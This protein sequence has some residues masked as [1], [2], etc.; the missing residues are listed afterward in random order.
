MTRFTRWVGPIAALGVI[1]WSSAVARATV[2]VEVPLEDMILGAD[3][4]VHG[5]VIANDVRMSLDR[6]ELEPNTFVT[7]EVTEWLA[8]EGGRTVTLRELGGTFQGI[9]TEVVGVPRYAVGDEVI[10]FLE[11][12]EDGRED[13]RT[14]AMAQGQFRVRHSLTEAPRVERDL[15]GVAFARWVDGQQTVQDPASPSM[16]LEAF[17]A[18]V[19]QTRGE[20]LPGAGGPATGGAV[21]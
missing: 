12:R 20:T 11:R 3:A 15:E 13:L 6:G 5:R 16:E 14:M 7:I 21:R 8:G 1:L 19:R 10:V 18:Y 4:I 17:K 2:M 9:T